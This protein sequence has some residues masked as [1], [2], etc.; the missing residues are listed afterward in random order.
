VVLLPIVQQYGLGGL[1]LSG[2]MAGSLLVMLGLARLGRLIEVVPYPV[3]VGFTSGIAVVIGVLQIKD[4][5][6][7]PLTSLE[8]HFVH[9]L[10]QIVQ[11][12]PQI[13]W[14][15]SFIGILT[16]LILIFWSRLRS[17]VPGHMVALLIGTVAALILAHINNDFSVATIGSRFQF[18][19]DGLTGGGIPP[20]LPEFAWPW[21]QPGP[22]GTQLSL[23]FGLIHDLIGP[24]LTIAMLGAIES[25]LC[26]VVADGMSGK[27]HSP[28][29][30]L[31]G[32]GIGNMLVPFVGGI[33]ATAAIA[34]TAANIRAGATSPLASIIHGL[35]I[36]C[37]I[38]FLAP[39]LSYIPMSALA[40]LLLV[41][42]WNMSEAKAFI[43]TIKIAR[44]EDVITLLTCFTLTVVFDMVIAVAV[45]MGMAAM[46]FIRRSIQLTEIKR[47]DNQEAHPHLKDLPK[48]ICIYD[49]NG[50]LFFGS[51]QK[52]L[53][54]I[55]TVN[56]GVKVIILDMGDVPMLD[57]SAIIVLENI[58]SSLQKQRIGLVFNNLQPRLILKIRHLGARRKEGIVDFSRNMEE[59]IEIA[60]QSMI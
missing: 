58:V 59:A 16:L 38:L 60:R 42:A 9:K 2:F 34:R 40:A 54:S 12:L 56:P 27:K 44:R 52:A 46:L 14:Q 35:F 29:D 3:T 43:R 23:S 25:L 57:M 13:N 37:A 5:F 33:P 1:L 26:A 36:L 7:L 49:M 20:F 30:E 8:G 31:I 55:T 17:R 32:Q 10:W 50:P 48:E 11:A 18:V 28:N 19:K 39:Y 53:R 21:Q 4:F 47:L 51:A 15:E 6:G 45:G 22:D 41:V 24:A